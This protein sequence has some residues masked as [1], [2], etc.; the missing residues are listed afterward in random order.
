MVVV[1]PVSPA[2]WM[3]HRN[4]KLL[5]CLKEAAC[6]G[7]LA[8][9]SLEL[10]WG[11]H[12]NWLH[13]YTNTAKCEQAMFRNLIEANELWIGHVNCS[14]LRTMNVNHLESYQNCITQDMKDLFCSV[15]INEANVTCIMYLTNKIC[16][17][18][19]IRCKR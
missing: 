4:G 11:K 16:F 3:S 9:P 2:S 8:F 19:A 14:N 7:L 12:T 10:G 17:D 13:L 15:D 18:F 1:S 6:L 5:I